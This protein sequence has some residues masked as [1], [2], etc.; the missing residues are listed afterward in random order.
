MDKE[1]SVSALQRF[2]GQKIRLHRLDLVVER[3]V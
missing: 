2:G 1:I 3:K